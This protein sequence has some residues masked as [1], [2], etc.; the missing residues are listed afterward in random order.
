MLERLSTLQD[1][2]AFVSVLENWE[3]VTPLVA[4]RQRMKLALFGYT[5][6]GDLRPN[7]WLTPSEFAL[8][9][10][11]SQ[12]SKPNSDAVPPRKTSLHE[13]GSISPSAFIDWIQTLANDLKT[14]TGEELQ[15]QGHPYPRRG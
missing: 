6:R 3:R 13:F 4:I 12:P 9:S 14:H 10:A 7:E 11:L 8:V 1:A 5:E 2:D 15:F